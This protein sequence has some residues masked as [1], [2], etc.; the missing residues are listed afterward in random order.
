LAPNKRGRVNNASSD[1]S[2]AGKRIDLKDTPPT[3]RPAAQAPRPED[4]PEDIPESDHVEV[5]TPWEDEGM[6][7]SGSESGG[8]ESVVAESDGDG[9]DDGGNGSDESLLTVAHRVQGQQE[10][11]REVY[12]NKAGQQTPIDMTMTPREIRAFLR[13]LFDEEIEQRM[14]VVQRKLQ[15]DILER[16]EAEKCRRTVLVFGI[17]KWQIDRQYY[18][19]LQWEDIITEDIQRLT[20]HRVHVTDVG[21]F[22]TTQGEAT[23]ARVSFASFGQKLTFYRHLAWITKEPDSPVKLVS[24]RDSFPAKYATAVGKMNQEGM[25]LKQ[26]GKCTSFRVIARGLTCEP[27]LETRN[28][29]GAW[30]IIRRAQEEEIHMGQTVAAEKRRVAELDRQKAAA[31]AAADAAAAT[32]AVVATGTTG[33]TINKVNATASTGGLATG[34]PAVGGS[35][36]GGPA[37]GGPA[38][39]ATTG[40][41]ARRSDS[42]NTVSANSVTSGRSTGSGAAGGRAV[43]FS[44]NTAQ[45]QLPRSAAWDSDAYGPDYRYSAAGAR[46]YSVPAGATA[47][48]QAAYHKEQYLHFNSQAVYNE[49]MASMAEF[50]PMPVQ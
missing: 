13:E 21:V 48:E 8:V 22:R 27:Y 41:L 19:G 37:A 17:R 24:F 26:A 28:G 45:G 29:R 15:Q 12:R 20:C 46:G 32:A 16:E 23:G 39:G 3:R 33:A 43:R 5:T 44:E 38:A 50:P 42:T 18:N 49:T 11:L 40:A 34:G 14:Q 7:H 9:G 47:E 35:A 4:F 6:S 2:E 10:L 31:K 25:R 36:V 1:E 30:T